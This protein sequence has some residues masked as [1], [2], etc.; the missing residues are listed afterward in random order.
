MGMK[1]SSIIALCVVL[2]CGSLI[3]QDAATQIANGDIINMLRAH[4]PENTIISEI[5]V[6]VGQGATFNISPTA[7]VE[8]QRAGAS[9][10]VLNA[11]VYIQTNVVPGLM[12]SVPRGVFYRTGAN[13]AE[14]RSFLLWPEF[15]PRWETWPFYPTGAKTMAMNASPVVVQVADGSPTLLAQ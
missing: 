15:I 11:I 7:I 14:L 13:A 2:N 10:K 9:E 12:I 1:V 8:L 5:N 4:V 3:A 6:L